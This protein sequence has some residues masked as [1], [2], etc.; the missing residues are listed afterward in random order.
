MIY[1]GVSFYYPLVCTRY[2]FPLVHLDVLTEAR[3][4]KTHHICEMFCILTCEV[5]TLNTLL[6]SKNSDWYSC[7]H[8]FS[9]S[10]SYNTFPFLGSNALTQKKKLY[11][12]VFQKPRKTSSKNKRIEIKTTVKTTLWPIYFHFLIRNTIE[13][14]LFHKYF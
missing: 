2:N 11:T 5:L 12:L 8:M 6:L 14:I 9:T 1:I 3:H 7:L 4:K 13:K 10:Q